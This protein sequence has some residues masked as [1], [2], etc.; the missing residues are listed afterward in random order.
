MTY[1]R[2]W[3]I[4]KLIIMSIEI[5]ISCQAILITDQLFKFNVNMISAF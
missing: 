4:S 5:K 1:I 3:R 2:A